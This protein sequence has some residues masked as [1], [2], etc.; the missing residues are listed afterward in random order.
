MM[1][2]S[3]DF[4]DF[5][6]TM[7]TTTTTDGQTDYTLPLAHAC[8][9]INKFCLLALY[10]L[11]TYAVVIGKLILKLLCMHNSPVASYCI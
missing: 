9:V 2:T 7:T 8:G 3:R 11:A 10:M 5:L 1:P 6:W 4:S